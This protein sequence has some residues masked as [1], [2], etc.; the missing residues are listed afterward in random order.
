M[1]YQVILISSLRLAK[2][3]ALLFE[4]LDFEE[5]VFSNGFYSFVV[6]NGW[7]KKYVLYLVRSKRI[8]E[9][10]DNNIYRGIGI[11][12]Y[13]VEDFL[14]IE[15]RDTPLYE[16]NQTVEKIEVIEKEIEQLKETILSDQD[17]IDSRFCF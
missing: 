1:E 3:P 7:N 17:I 2:S 15:V 4:T 5:Y 6:H 12:S 8:K 13:R 10:L 14:R 16:Q 9:N 11:S